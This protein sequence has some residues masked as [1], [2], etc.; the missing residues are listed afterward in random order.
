MPQALAFQPSSHS[1]LCAA[2]QLSTFWPPAFPRGTASQEGPF[3]DTADEIHL[4][5][6]Q[7]HNNDDES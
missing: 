1:W 6:E 3:L 7:E 4:H 5:P 2:S